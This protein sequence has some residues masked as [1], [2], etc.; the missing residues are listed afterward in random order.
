LTKCRKDLFVA[1]PS[2]S[3]RIVP[4]SR[5]TPGVIT[6]EVITPADKGSDRHRNCDLPKPIPK[7]HVQELDSS[8]SLSRNL[9]LRKRLVSGISVIDA[10]AAPDGDSS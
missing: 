10:E 2:A 5:A 1:D 6:P 9:G 4:G 8:A 3:L 7:R